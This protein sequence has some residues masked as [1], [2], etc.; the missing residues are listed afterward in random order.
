MTPIGPINRFVL[1]R[2]SFAYKPDAPPALNDVSATIRAGER[3][4]SSAPSAAARA[5]GETPDE[6]A[7][8]CFR[9]ILAN[10]LALGGIDPATLRHDIGLV[11]QN[12]MLFSGTIRANLVMHRPEATTT[13]SSTPARWPA[14]SD[15]ST[16]CRAD[17]TRCW[18][19]VATVFLADSGNPWRWARAL[20]GKPATLIL[21]EPTSDMDGRS[22]AEIVQ[23]L[24]QHLGQ[25]TLILVTHRPALLDLVDRLIVLD[26]GKVMAD[27][28]KAEVLELLRRQ[29]AQR[30]TAPVA[31]SA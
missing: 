25:R 21:D 12:P 8:A 22:E 17:S 5:A 10:D 19:N 11:E 4:R 27:G 15:G 13:M 24:A 9:G 1:E 6:A 29:G 14:R 3:S 30:E 7:S 2:V 20:V 31:R 23:R 16:A 18:A 26:A 28:P